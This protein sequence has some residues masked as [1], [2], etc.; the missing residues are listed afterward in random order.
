[1]K[2]IIMASHLPDGTDQ[3]RKY[4]YL[5]LEEIFRDACSDPMAWEVVPKEGG[6]EL[7]YSQRR[8]MST[9]DTI[10]CQ[11][12]ADGSHSFTFE[13]VG[14]GYLLNFEQGEKCR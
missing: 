14:G 4:Q 13:Q 9:G 12:N 10:T 7:F 2:P 3:R 11:G 1:M 6:G 8:N 5:L